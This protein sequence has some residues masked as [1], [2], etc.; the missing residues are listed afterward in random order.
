MDR[1]RK[2]K[3]SV[4]AYD[5]LNI[6]YRAI[7]YVCLEGGFENQSAIEMAKKV[8][9]GGALGMASAGAAGAL[10]NEFAIMTV[11]D[12]YLC[13]YILNKFSMNFYIEDKIVLPYETITKLKVKRFLINWSNFKV[14]FAIDGQNRKIKIVIA[15]RSF[16]LKN[17]R[18][19]IK[20]FLDHLNFKELLN[21]RH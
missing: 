18:E 7:L 2:M 5:P 1:S 4:E 15:H 14:H 8:P 19:N 17:Q 3:E 9:F 12:D 21:H 16:G 11:N 20:V 6:D 10:S 13:F